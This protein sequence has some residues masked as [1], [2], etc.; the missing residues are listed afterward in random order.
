VTDED[1]I[2]LNPVFAPDG[3]SIVFLAASPNGPT[4]Q[5]IR[6]GGGTP[7]VIA[8][9]P[10]I[11]NLSG[12]TWSRD[13]I[14]AGSVA[15]GGVFRVPSSGGSPERII[16]VASDETAHRPQMLPDGHTVLF[17]LAKNVGEDRWDKAEI[18]AQSLADKSRRVLI[19]GGSDGRYVETGHLLYTVGGTTYAVLFDADTLTVKGSA[20]P[21]VPGVRRVTGGTN[22]A[23][24]LTTSA[25][26]TMAYLPG[27]AAALATSRGLVIG[28]GRGDAVPLKVPA[29]VYAHP[30]VSPNGQMLAVSRSEG[31][32]SDIWT[33]DLSPNAEIQRLTFGGQS[34]FPVWSADSRRVTFQSTRDHAIW[35]QT[36]AGGIAERLTSPAQGEEHAPESWSPDGTRLLFSVHK[37]SVNTLWMLTL[38]GLKAEPLGQVQSLESL[39]ASFSPDGRW[40]AYAATDRLGGAVSPNR[41]VFV[42]PFPPTGAKRQ[43]PKKLLDYHPRWSPDG[44]AIVYVSGAGRPLVTIPVRLEPSIAFGSPVE[45]TRAPMPGLLSLDVR[46]YDLLRDGRIVSVAS[47]ASQDSFGSPGEVRVVLNWFEELKRM[48]PTK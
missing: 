5:R 10:G 27:P 41:G 28:D 32:A 45:M 48:V 37:E 8:T 14:L 25:T 18:V 17:T 22:G 20:V 39:S 26:G 23:T 3:E 29:A 30:R 16:N 1:T 7:A 33:Y 47:A 19:Q 36:V 42:E 43:A 11:T 34:R 40:I 13:E 31:R 2:A 21:V 9:F 24:Q 15:G 35:W 6:V 38:N 4:I 12:L 46:G 44:K